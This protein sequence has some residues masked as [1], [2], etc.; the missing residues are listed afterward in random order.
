MIRF[1]KSFFLRNQKNIDISQIEKISKYTNS[2]PF[3]IGDE[4]EFINDLPLYGFQKGTIYTVYSLFLCQDN[5]KWFVR[6]IERPS[7]TLCSD[8]RL[9]NKEGICIF[10]E[11]RIEL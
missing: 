4:I 10:D 11:S 5:K 6:T 7:S 8:F 2:A 1:L 3:D 9:Y